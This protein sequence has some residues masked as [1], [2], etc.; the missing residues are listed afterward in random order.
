MAAHLIRKFSNQIPIWLLKLVGNF[1]FP[2]FGA[3][4]K[5]VEVSKDYHYM[6]VVLKRRWYN[7]NYVGTQFGGSMYA[8]TDPFYMIMLIQI[9]GR[10]YIVWDKAASIEFKKPGK[11]DLTAEFRINREQ[12]E[13]IKKNTD[14]YDKF[15][16]DIPVEIFDEDKVV[17]ASVQKTLYV[18]KKKP[19]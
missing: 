12:I 2:F 5:I 16:F 13:L 11:S 4:I 17:V 10:E 1:W 19:N 6:K 8:M 14:N 3:G 18:R 15:V 7:A 9:L